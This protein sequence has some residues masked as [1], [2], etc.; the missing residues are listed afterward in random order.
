MIKVSTRTLMG[1]SWFVSH[2][3]RVALEVRASMY[4]HVELPT[5]VYIIVDLF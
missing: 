5:S 3:W 2:C 4:F 1:H